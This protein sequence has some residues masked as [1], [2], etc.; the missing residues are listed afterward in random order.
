MRLGRRELLQNVRS[1]CTLLK[2]MPTRLWV[3]EVINTK[4]SEI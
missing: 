1:I 2:Y 3:M 4:I